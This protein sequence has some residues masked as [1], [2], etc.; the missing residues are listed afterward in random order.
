MESI[1]R[2]FQLCIGGGCVRSDGGFRDQLIL[3]DWITYPP[4]TPP[5]FDDSAVDWKENGKVNQEET[6]GGILVGIFI[7]E[8]IENAQD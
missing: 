2:P 4:P 7:Q 3:I 5:S 6:K 1:C 8:V